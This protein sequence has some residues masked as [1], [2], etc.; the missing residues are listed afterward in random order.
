MTENGKKA[1]KIINDSFKSWSEHW[2]QMHTI[3]KR[4]PKPWFDTEDEA[5]QELKRTID[6]I[7]AVPAN[8]QFDA[9]YKF[10]RFNMQSLFLTECD[11]YNLFWILEQPEFIR[12]IEQ[13]YADYASIVNRFA[14]SSNGSLKIKNIPLSI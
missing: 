9:K 5:Y 10:V 3:T 14:R 11:S 8:M 7:E 1:M 13:K 4:I 2:D 6:T 12:T